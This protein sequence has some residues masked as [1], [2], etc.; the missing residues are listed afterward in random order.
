MV[1]IINNNISFTYT[2]EN[3]IKTDIFENVK[4]TYIY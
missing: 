1:V 3:V 4:N 2:W